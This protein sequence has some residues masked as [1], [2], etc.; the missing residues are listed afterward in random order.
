MLSHLLFV[1]SGLGI[2]A[3]KI[4]GPYFAVWL[5]AFVLFVMEILLVLSYEEEDSPRNIIFTIL[6]YFTYCQM[7]LIIVFRGLFL[8]LRRHRVGVWDKTERFLT[9]EKTVESVES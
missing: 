4:P 1:L 9:T 2:V 6:M 3:L 8:D 5:S 7:W